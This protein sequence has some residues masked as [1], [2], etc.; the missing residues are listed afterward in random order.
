MPRA[1]EAT[2]NDGLLEGG[3]KRLTCVALSSYFRT[4][5]TKEGMSRCQI[6][7]EYSLTCYFLIICQVDGLVHVG[8]GAAVW[9]SVIR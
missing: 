3:T 6:G 8:E 5:L 9:A 7:Q 2:V 1:Q 4:T